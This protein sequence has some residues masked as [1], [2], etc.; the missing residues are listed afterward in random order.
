[1]QVNLSNVGLVVSE[2]LSTVFRGQFPTP[3]R[4]YKHKYPQSWVV[5]VNKLC[6]WFFTG[7]RW[8]VWGAVPYW[9]TDASARVGVFIPL[10]WLLG[11]SR[12]TVDSSNWV[13]GREL[14]EGDV[15]KGVG[16]EI[17]PPKSVSFLSPISCWCSLFEIWRNSKRCSLGSHKKFQDWP[18]SKSYIDSNLLIAQ[19]LKEVAVFCFLF[20][21]TIVYF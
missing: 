16:R 8:W 19:F 13:I 9:K 4:G 1:M 6:R 5:T 17:H 20:I 11:P 10:G 15:Y 7:D 3:D 21:L 2:L 18:K 14:N 12:E